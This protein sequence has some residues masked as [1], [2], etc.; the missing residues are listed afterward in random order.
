M[1]KTL[2]FYKPEY[3]D[4]AVKLRDNYIA[5]DYEADIISVKE[6]DDVE[7]ARKMQ[8]DE[9]IFIEDLNTVIIHNI[10]T[11]YTERCLFSD[12]FY[13]ESKSDFD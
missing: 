8:Y 7:Y 10:K 13:E 5:H 1:K 3:I 9:A 6:Q 4:L 11:W 12:V 2:I